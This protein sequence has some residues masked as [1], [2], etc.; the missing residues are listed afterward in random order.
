MP[1]AA[2][3]VKE[4]STTTGT[5]PITLAGAVSGFLA[6]ATAFDNPSQVY[7][8]IDGGTE[9]EVGIGTFTTT[10][11]RDIVLKS[12]NSNA[13]VN[14]S[15]GSKSVFSTIPAQFVTLSDCMNAPAVYQQYIDGNIIGAL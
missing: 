9:W 12:S 11:A 15:A 3:R 1:R 10:L 14:F 4:T 5:G 7:Y 13:L 8:T 6:F 2:D